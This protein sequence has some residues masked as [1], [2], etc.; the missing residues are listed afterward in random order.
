MKVI[1]KFSRN[2]ELLCGNWPL[3]SFEQREGQG[4]LPHFRNHVEIEAQK[5]SFELT[6]NEMAVDISE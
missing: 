5:A 3:K 1:M 4:I 2:G 6:P